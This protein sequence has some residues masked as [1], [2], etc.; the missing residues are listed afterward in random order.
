MSSL[1][2][3]QQ[4][5]FELHGMSLSADRDAQIAILFSDLHWLMQLPSSPVP[6]LVLPRE[7]PPLFF[8]SSTI[9]PIDLA[10][11]PGPEEPAPILPVLPSPTHLSAVLTLSSPVNGA[12]FFFFFFF[13]F[14]LF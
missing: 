1:I 10:L 4:R 8:P 13:F 9:A 5:L 11:M 2:V 7:E 3:L 14:F 12:F 6:A